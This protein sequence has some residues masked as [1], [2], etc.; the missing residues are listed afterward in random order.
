MVCLIQAS[1]FTQLDG[2]TFSFI[3]FCKF[4]YSF[5]FRTSI[6][7]SFSVFL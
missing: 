4:S 7:D 5:N 2:Y 6:V 1:K 3:D